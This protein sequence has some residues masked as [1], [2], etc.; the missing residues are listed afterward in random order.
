MNTVCH[1]PGYFSNFGKKEI[2]FGFDGG[3]ITSDGGSLLVAR[4]MKK[5]NTVQSITKCLIDDRD[6]VKVRHSQHELI[7]QRIMLLVLGYEDCNDSNHLRNDPMIKSAL[8]RLPESGKG[9]A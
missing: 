8:G 4:A 7:E 3:N 2:R 1:K 9:L 6:Q 5:M